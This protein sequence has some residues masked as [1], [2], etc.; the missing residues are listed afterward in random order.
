MTTNGK[1]CLFPFNYFNSSE[2]QLEYRI[3][4]SLDVYR[5]WCPTKLDGQKNVLEWGDCLDDCP[6]EIPNVVCLDEPIFP[7]FADGSN[8]AVNYTANYTRG[9]GVVT[10]EVFNYVLN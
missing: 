3:C 5:P 4:S 10:Y 2:P 7:D 1:K 6:S 8:N 9:S